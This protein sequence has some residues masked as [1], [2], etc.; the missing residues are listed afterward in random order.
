VKITNSFNGSC[1]FYKNDFVESEIHN[2]PFQPSK[3][4]LNKFFKVKLKKPNNY[5]G[6]FY[7]NEYLKSTGFE[8]DLIHNEEKESFIIQGQE[9]DNMK[10]YMKQIS[11]LLDKK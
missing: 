11:V 10:N 4:F 5:F 8:K 2:S 1:L 9:I 6:T 7:K 3:L